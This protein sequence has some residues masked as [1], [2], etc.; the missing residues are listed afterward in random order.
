MIKALKIQLVLILLL[1]LTS[2][3]ELPSTWGA[4]SDFNPNNTPNIQETTTSVYVYANNP[5][6]TNSGVTYNSQYRSTIMI[7]ET[8]P[9][10][11]GAGNGPVSNFNYTGT[12]SGTVILCAQ[13]N[14]LQGGPGTT[15]FISQALSGG[16]L[17]GFSTFGQN[18]CQYINGIPV[19]A[20]TDSGNASGSIEYIISQNVPDN[21]TQGTPIPNSS[22]V[23]YVDPTIQVV[24]AT[25]AN[26][27]NG[28]I[29]LRIIDN[30][31]P[32]SASNYAD[33]YGRYQ[34]VISQ[35]NI[36][37]PGSFLSDLA[38]MVINPITAQIDTISQTMFETG[39]QSQ[40]FMNI[41]RAALVLYIVLYG[42]TFLIG[43]E[44]ITQSDFFVRIVKIGII[45][46]LISPTGLSFF[47]T[48]LFSLFKN[49]QRELI[50]LITDPSAA[51]VETGQLNYNSLFAFAD[52]AISTFFSSHFFSVLSA[53]LMW[54]PIGWV[55]LILLLYAIVVYVFAI[56][57]VVIAYV[58]AYTAIGLLIALGPVFI[59][60]LLF[61]Q[62]SHLFG[63]WIRAMVTYMMEPVIMFAGIILI[64]AFVNDTLYNLLNLQLQSVPIIPIFLDF[65]SLGKLDL[66][67]IY[68]I[69]PVQ[70]TMQILTDILIFY[71]FIEL[72]K[73]VTKISEEIA[74]KIFE[75][76]GTGGVAGGMV[77]SIKT[78]MN[79]AI[80][81]P[82]MATK[83]A[84][85]AIAKRTKRDGQSKQD[86]KSGQDD[87]KSNR[88][89]A[90]NQDSGGSNQ[91]G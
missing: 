36:E 78:G 31:N 57:E 52:Y 48:Y 58:I 27:Q 29:W 25:I 91:R 51:S 60:L 21:A 12:A 76:G 67:T 49:G 40:A 14:A 26:G 61:K 8:T 42:F 64:T 33:N 20:A 88:P 59:P 73:K 84:F 28:T 70:P 68:W 7:F 30:P 75:S 39:S 63:A 32:Y 74:N 19:T 44:E 71:I 72:L 53:F 15:G 79:A 43:A 1:V 62:T 65:G 6:W 35:P 38:E 82:V 9:Q 23:P 87:S 86:S 18:A 13:T 22:I 10:Y 46:T 56:L 24:G 2:C 50:N 16:S 69:N 3:N 41:I 47:N 89:A 37:V 4:S 54:F 17:S 77:D 45:L 5:A 80:G 11:S 55:C 34:V 81:A 90:A 66:F 83:A 85:S